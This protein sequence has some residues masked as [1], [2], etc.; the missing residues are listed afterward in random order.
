IDIG[1]IETPTLLIR[2][3]NSEFTKREDLWI[4]KEK[5]P[6]SKIATIDSCGHWVMVEKTIMFLKQ[7][8]SYI[9]VN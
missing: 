6:N 5:L 7:L 4:F 1:I 8:L 2:G 3:D 9:G